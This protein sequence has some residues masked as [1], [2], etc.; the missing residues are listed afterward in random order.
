MNVLVT[1]ASGFVG[2]E[3]T[4]ALWKRGHRVWGIG[5]N[6]LENT[7]TAL[8]R[9]YSGNLASDT[10]MEL[11]IRQATPEAVVHLAGQ[12]SVAASWRDTSDT[13]DSSVVGSVNLF[14]MLR[15][16]GAPVHTF[17]N[18]GSAEEYAPSD[19]PLTEESP[20]G[21]SNPYGIMKV[22]QA[23]TLRL[24][25]TESSIRLIHFRPFNHIGPGQ[26]RNFVISDWA[27]QITHSAHAPT[28]SV[29]NVKVV[30][31]FTDVRDVVRAYVQAAEGDV[32]EGT[33]NLASGVGRSLQ[34]VLEDLQ[35]YAGIVAEIQVDPSR[36]R[37]GDASVRV[38][39]SR[40]LF[41]LMGWKPEIPWSVTIRDILEWQR[42]VG[43]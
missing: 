38:G 6:A 42:Q 20:I 39:S 32:P 29:G 37:P 11:F 43:Y 13:I 16:T 1:G 5:R 8:W 33:Y 7:P 30:R 18:V 23:E 41:E 17:V 9:Y 35:W 15:R 4:Q 12:A 27:Y 28:I 40:K 31:D 14:L 2:S 21:P 24:L 3:I 22:A 25:F 26:H 19:I 36:F 34:S 10:G